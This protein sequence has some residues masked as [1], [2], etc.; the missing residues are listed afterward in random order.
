M[1][2]RLFSPFQSNR[3]DRSGART[4]RAVNAHVPSVVLIVG[5]ALLFT[6]LTAAAMII[7]GGEHATPPPA[8]R[9]STAPTTFTP[10]TS[11]PTAL[12]TR[13]TTD[14]APSVA[15]PV[16][17]AIPAI[18]VSAKVEPKG[19]T[20]KGQLDVPTNYSRVGWWFGGHKPGERG[21]AVLEGHVDSKKGPAVFYALRR[22]HAGDEIR[23]VRRDMSTAV[24]VVDRLI[25]YAKTSFPSLD[26]YGP[27]DT[28]SLRLITCTGSFN[29]SR[30]SYRDNL[31]VYATLKT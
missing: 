15:P 11:T 16:F 27:T 22:L 2:R 24:F 25:S 29:R 26:V 23:V 7:A 20:R 18:K 1:T 13:S 9:A 30:H 3:H 17:V 8:T 4:I 19:L 21:T 10:P 5:A 14:A 12:P 6:S 31:V 28:A